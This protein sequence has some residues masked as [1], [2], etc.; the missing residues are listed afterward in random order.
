MILVQHKEMN[1]GKQPFSTIP[2]DNSQRELV[3]VNLGSD[4]KIPHI[5]V[6]GDT[7]TILLKGT[8]TDGRFCLIDMYVFPGSGSPPHRP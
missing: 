8:D 7:Y 3:N 6:V 2:S 1:T 4:S 5:G